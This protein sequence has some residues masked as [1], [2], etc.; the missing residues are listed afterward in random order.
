MKRE[1]AR[2]SIRLLS[3][4]LLAVVIFVSTVFSGLSPAV[5]LVFTDDAQGTLGP[6]CNVAGDGACGSFAQ[7][8]MGIQNVAPT[9]S[10]ALFNTGGFR[11]T[12]TV[13]NVFGT[14]SFSPDAASVGNSITIFM[15]GKRH[16][17]WDAN[18]TLQLLSSLDMVVSDPGSLLISFQMQTN[19][20]LGVMPGFAAI[21]NGS[22]MASQNVST[23]VTKG[24][25]VKMDTA[26]EADLLGFFT[27]R[28]TPTQ[29]NATND[30]KFSFANSAD[31]LIAS[32][33]EPSTWILLA[34]GVAFLMT[35]HR[36]RSTRRF[37]R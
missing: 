20:S 12:S 6:G 26:G 37:P 29:N 23:G 19:F 9:G 33:P 35:R 25:A 28:F 5:A 27:A 13:N 32:V 7:T 15:N 34:A 2:I 30:V 1:Q 14:L 18:E 4:L 36:L 11:F 3:S 16:V 21:T 8:F 31:A 22:V 24:K 10:V 17:K